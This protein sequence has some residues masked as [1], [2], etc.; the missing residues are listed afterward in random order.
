MKKCDIS[1]PNLPPGTTPKRGGSCDQTAGT[2]SSIPIW[3][4]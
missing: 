3:R 2:V 1:G 4:L